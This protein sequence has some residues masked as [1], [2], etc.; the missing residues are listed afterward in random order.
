MRGSTRATG[1]RRYG[2]FV[3]GAGLDV[4]DVAVD[5]NPRR[6]ERVVANAAHLVDHALLGI[7]DREPVDI[8]RGIRAAAPVLELQ[9]GEIGQIVDPLECGQCDREVLD[10][11]AG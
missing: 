3:E 4:V 5:R 7:G 10:R 9:P 2:D 11:E 8:L 1:L 6:D